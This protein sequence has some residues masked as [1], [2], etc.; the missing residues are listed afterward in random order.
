MK[1][2]AELSDHLSNFFSTEVYHYN[3]LYRWLKYTDGVQAFA[4]HAG[5]GAY[6]FLDIIGT[7]LQSI[8]NKEEFMSIT[9][10]SKNGSAIISADDGN[11]NALW[12][13]NIDFT[14]CPE[15][16]WQFFLQYGVLMLRSEY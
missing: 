14:D 11:G 9:L 10:D 2:P 5:G 12:S 1:D 13:K 4:Q 16:A 8:A 6:W 7:E 3:P 15:G